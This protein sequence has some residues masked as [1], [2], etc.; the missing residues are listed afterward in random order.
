M[1]DGVRSVKGTA[2]DGL[3][4]VVTVTMNDG[5]ERTFYVKVSES[6][7]AARTGGR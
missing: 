6:T 3:V 7:G 1:P 2:V 4:T 5:S